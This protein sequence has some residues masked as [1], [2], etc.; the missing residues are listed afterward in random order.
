M[1]SRL[2]FKIF[3][4]LLSNLY[5]VTTHLYFNSLGSPIRLIP[6]I[7]K[8]P[9]RKTKIYQKSFYKL[10]MP[11]QTFTLIALVPLLGWFQSSKSTR[12]HQ[13]WKSCKIL[14]VPKW[15]VTQQTQFIKVWSNLH[16]YVDFL[17]NFKSWQLFSGQFIIILNVYDFTHEYLDL[18][19]MGFPQTQKEHKP[20]T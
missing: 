15:N 8:Q 6:V 16:T 9:L 18:D 4:T 1:E 14:E 11:S 13:I 5:T 19:H 12:N 7:F 20:R 2:P 17:S 10:G 3:S